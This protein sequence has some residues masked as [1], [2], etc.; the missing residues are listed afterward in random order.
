MPLLTINVT[1]TE[2][3]P[4]RQEQ[5]VIPLI[6][7]IRQQAIQL[8]MNLLNQT[9][10]ST[11]ISE[12]TRNMLNYAG[13]GEVTIDQLKRDKQRGLRII[14]ADKGP[15][16]ANISQAMEN[17][18]SS[19]MGM[20]LGLPGAKRLVDEF[21]ITSVVGQGTTVTISKWANG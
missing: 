16:I 8:G 20:G 14:F 4:V 21:L 10:L 5:D 12:L 2:T 6:S 15:G 9:K 3:I 17:G 1:A 7:S 13:G 18:Y 11:A 19:G